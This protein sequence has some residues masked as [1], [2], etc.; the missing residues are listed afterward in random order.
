MKQEK[1]SIV[2]FYVLLL[3]TAAV[4]LFLYFLPYSWKLVHSLVSHQ[5]L[6][7]EDTYL[8][9]YDYVRQS[10]PYYREF[11]RLIDSGQIFWS[12]NSFLGNSFYTSKALFLIGD[13]FAWFGYLLFQVISYL[14]TVQF[15]L[16]GLRL[17]TACVCCSVWLRR[18]HR[19]DRSVTLFSILFMFSG[20]SDVFLEQV[21]FLSFYAFLPLFLAGLE[22][23][24]QKRRPYLLAFASALLSCINFYLLWP[25]GVFG[26]LYFIVRW[27]QSKQT[28]SGGFS[29]SFVGTA[30]Q[31]LVLILLGIGLAGF[32]V[33]PTLHAMLNS[34]RLSTSLNYYSH[35]SLTNI[36]AIVM[37][38]FIPV[39]RGN[40]LLYHDYWYYFYQI[41]TY[42]GTLSLLLV[43]QAFRGKK[44]N[45]VIFAVTLAMFASPQ[46]GLFFHLTYS[47]RYSFM[48]VLCLVLL[49][50][51]AFENALEPAV[52]KRSAA[53]LTIIIAC[54]GVVI[55]A[56]SGI[57]FHDHYPERLMLGAGA[58]V[59]ILETVLLIRGR[60]K[61]V[62]VLAVLEALLFGNYSMRSAIS[63]G[64]EAEYLAYDEEIQ[65]IMTQLKEMD[66]SFF[67]VDLETGIQSDQNALA[68]AGMYYGIPSLSSYDSLYEPAL[69]DYLSWYGLYPDVSWQFN[70][71]DAG[72]FALLDAK[73]SICSPK[74]SSVRSDEPLFSS[75]HFNVYQNGSV[76]GMAF[77][78]R[79]LSR[80]S[81]LDQ[82]AEQPEENHKRILLLLETTAV[83]P[84][85]RY[86]ELL[87]KCSE[88]PMS[89]SPVSF[90]G[91]SLSFTMTNDADAFWVF[92][93]PAAQGW[94]VTV[95]GQAAQTIV[96]DGGFIGL[97]LPAGT[98]DILFQYAV[99]M[100]KEGVGISVCSG[101]VLA[102]LALFH[103][104]RTNSRAS[105][106]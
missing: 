53:V 22:D 54:L 20:W 82:L 39:I 79:D 52:L 18:L 43:P 76:K 56:F 97:V 84:D 3:L 105:R 80:A 101:I 4:L 61:A 13:P 32:L 5:S 10:L 96:S 74:Y 75:E 16:T 98:S 7:L 92:S 95:N 47:L 2:R 42:A 36:C 73:Y 51:E 70:L 64:S 55:P 71:Q 65:S 86:D 14:P 91:T 27:K 99:P 49:G 72:Q 25:L 46:I 33:V 100:F 93:V 69:H 35:W 31:S 102:G 21:Q 90:G 67:R 41:G 28:R 89:A 87:D 45:R 24:I 50:S 104:R 68:N 37:S 77:R 17:L 63:E 81:L 44:W 66:S 58:V 1:H 60:K 6:S 83:V 29:S 19:S 15:L 11:Y 78:V 30:L 34:P 62:M 8:I 94:S 103:H 48:A 88:V 106:H 26:I 9:S 23:M 85:D 12:W 57:S 59:V 40:N 38:F